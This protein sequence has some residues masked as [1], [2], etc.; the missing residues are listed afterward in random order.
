MSIVIDFVRQ[1]IPPG[2]RS[3]ANGWTSGNCPMCVHNG[4]TRPDTRRR[5]GFY[6]EPDK[7]QY[8]CFNCGYKTGWSP[9]RPVN[10]RLAKLLEVLGAEPADVQRIKLELARSEELQQVLTRK[11]DEAKP[12]VFDW[13]EIELPAVAHSLYDWARHYIDS[14]ED[15]SQYAK[16]VEYA[17]SR[18]F[19]LQD[20]RLYWSNSPVHQTDHRLLIPFTYRGRP[21]G[22][23]GRWSVGDKPDSV[24]KYYTQVPK[25]FVFNLDAQHSE[26]R[27]MFVVEGPI[28][29]LYIDGVAV[30]SNECSDTQGKI[31]E[32]HAGDKQIVLVP[33]RDSAGRKLVNQALKRGWSVSFPPWHEDIKDVGDAVDRY[34]KLFTLKSIIASIENNEGKCQ[35]LSKK[36]C[37]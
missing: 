34:G 17:T 7:F 28:D 29:A 11:V 32:E 35:L 13:P 27:Y 31:I 36:Y 5:G 10:P 2:W 19:D 24:P 20:R 25:N 4:Q 8:N 16:V 33:D 23:T 3:T 21:V 12:A 22:Y 6:F 30:L 14:D 1:Y 26:R 9:G 37:K 15:P 18:N